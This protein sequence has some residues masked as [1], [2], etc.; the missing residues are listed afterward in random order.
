[1]E[2]RR[3][4]Q[5]GLERCWEKGCHV[6]A[7]TLFDSSALGQ[8]PWLRERGTVRVSRNRCGLQRASLRSCRQVIRIPRMHGL[9]PITVGSIVIRSVVIGIAPPPWA[10]VLRFLLRSEEHTTELQ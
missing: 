7:P 3:C 8:C 6:V 2:L 4:K 9:P 1:M 10:V 5:G